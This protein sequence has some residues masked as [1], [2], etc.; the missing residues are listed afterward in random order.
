MGEEEGDLAGGCRRWE[1]RKGT[2]QEDA[3]DGRKGREPCRRMQEMREEEGG[4]CRRMQ[5]MG[6]KEGD[7][8][9][10]CRRWEKGG[11]RTKNMP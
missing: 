7:L 6:E 3:G 5:E 11:W 1:K 4:P 8:A 10:G 9:G 2:L